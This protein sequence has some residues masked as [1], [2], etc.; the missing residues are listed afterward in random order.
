MKDKTDLATL[1]ICTFVV[2]LVGF[3]I[4]SAMQSAMFLYTEKFSVVIVDKGTEQTGFLWLVTSFYFLGMDG[5]RWKAFEH[6]PVKLYVTEQ[7]YRQYA[8]GS[9]FV[10]DG[11]N[12]TTTLDGMIV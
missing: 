3:S 9:V 6:N 10:W 11:P 5:V 8:V 7:E 12:R 2:I 1:A 4:V